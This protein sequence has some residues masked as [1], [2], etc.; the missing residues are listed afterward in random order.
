MHDDT[1]IVFYCPD[2]RGRV[3]IPEADF[4]EGEV[5]ECYLCA[6]EILVMQ[7]VPARIKLFREEDDF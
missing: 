4:L 1:V 7:R 3:E 2:C 6:A 5:L